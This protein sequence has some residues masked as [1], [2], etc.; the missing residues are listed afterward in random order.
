MP[1]SAC[2]NLPIC[3]SVAPVNEP[4]SWPK[5]S[6]SISSSGIAAQ[7]TWMKRSRL[8][9]LLR[10]IA[11]ATSSLPAPL[12]PSSS[13]VALVGA[14]RLIASQIWRSDALSPTIWWRA[15]TARF[16]E[17]F[18]STQPRLVERVA[19]RDQHALARQRLLDEVEGAELGRLDRGAHRAVPGD[20]HDR[21]RLV[22][23]PDLLQRL[24][25]VHAAGILMSRNTRSGGSRSTSASASG[26]LDASWTS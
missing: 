11:R 23:L 12:S 13:T 17:R 22:D 26:P 21:Q 9:R 15:S 7:L 24:E 10:W 5:S 14:A 4:F 3:F 8:R 2:S 25:A 20:D 6:D 18:S 16:S 1:R 19:D